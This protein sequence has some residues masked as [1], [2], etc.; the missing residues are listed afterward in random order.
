MNDIERAVERLA[1][2]KNLLVITGAGI[3]HESGIPTFRGNDGLWQNYRAEELATPEA[4]DAI[5]KLSGNG[6]TGDGASLA[7]PSR[8]ADILP[9]RS[10]RS[11]MSIFSSL[12]RMLMV[13]TDV[14]AIQRWLRFTETSGG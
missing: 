4:F 10:W 11:Y 3:S 14:Q 2:S 7:G 8:M 5:P 9:S 13:S 6:M 1:K 12:P